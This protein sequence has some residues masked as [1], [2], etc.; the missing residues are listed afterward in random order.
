MQNETKELI[1]LAGEGLRFPLSFPLLDLPFS[2]FPIFL[3]GVGVGVSGFGFGVFPS[4]FFL[5]HEWR[6]S[7]LSKLLVTVESRGSRAPE[8]REWQILLGVFSYTAIARRRMSEARSNLKSL[9]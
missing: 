2:L 9:K 7:A 3:S 6:I 5:R 8:P 1:R 4:P